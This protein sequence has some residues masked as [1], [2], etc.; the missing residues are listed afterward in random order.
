MKTSYIYIL[1]AVIIIAVFVYVLMNRNHIFSDL[2]DEEDEYEDDDTECEEEDGEEE[3]KTQA[4]FKNRRENLNSNISQ[5]T[6]TYF[7]KI[8]N[9]DDNDK[10]KIMSAIESSTNKGLDE[11]QIIS[12]PKEE[13]Q[14]V[15]A[16]IMY[17]EN[18]REEK[19]LMTNE[20]VCIGRDPEA[21]DIVISGDKFLGR[22]HALIYKKG[23]SIY[24]ADLNSK[25]GSFIE[26][27]RI[28]GKEE[29]VGTKRIKLAGTEFT[30]KVG[31]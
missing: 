3:E 16:S 17:K 18:G 8:P 15:Y 21:C 2:E 14:V 7:S 28:S 11:T 5:D 23:Q 6:N 30:V 10:T 26:G 29:I 4:L 24:L 27:L 25:N 1:I 20:V 9:L 19:F 12:I 31:D 22:Q 13:T